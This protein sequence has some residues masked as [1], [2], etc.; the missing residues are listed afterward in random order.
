MREFLAKL[1]QVINLQHLVNSQK[2]FLYKLHFQEKRMIHGLRHLINSDSM[3]SQ[4]LQ[5]AIL[6]KS[7]LER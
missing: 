5:N 3:S 7:M 2:M 1:L 4:L 6:V